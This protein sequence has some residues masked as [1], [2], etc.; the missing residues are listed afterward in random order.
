MVLD[1]YD[2]ACFDRKHKSKV[3]IS[4]PLFRR[5]DDFATFAL[6]VGDNVGEDWTIKGFLP[7]VTRGN[8]KQARKVFQRI[9]LR[10]SL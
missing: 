6:I 4:S 8:K 3:N 1:V 7:G 10:K 2:I 9:Q 5:F